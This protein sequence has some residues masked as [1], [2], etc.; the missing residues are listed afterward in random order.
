LKAGCDYISLVAISAAVYCECI[1]VVKL[2]PS[3]WHDT[4]TVD[5]MSASCHSLQGEK[6]DYLKSIE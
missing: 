3:P 1:S 2:T 6:I 5:S 4:M